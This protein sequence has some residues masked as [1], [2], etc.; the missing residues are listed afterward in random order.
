MSNKRLN[1]DG[2]PRIAEKVIEILQRCGPLKPKDI[3]RESA[4]G[5]GG[6]P[7]PVNA[8]NAALSIIFGMK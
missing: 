8:I 4:A 5:N 6:R 7:L 2:L 3:A 1:Y